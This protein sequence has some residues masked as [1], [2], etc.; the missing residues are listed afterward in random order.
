MNLHL[1]KIFKEDK[2]VA[3][4]LKRIVE[5]VLLGQRISEEEGILLYQSADLGMLSFLADAV[6]QSKNGN[7]ILHSQSLHIDLSNVC[8]Y[9]CPFCTYCQKKESPLAFT[10]SVKDLHDRLQANKGNKSYTEIV[11]SSA[12]HPDHTLNYYKE[13]V[14]LVRKTFPAAFIRAFSATDLSYI[15]K[16][17]KVSLNAGLAL[18][19]AAGVN[20]VNGG[21]AEI[22]SPEIRE[23]ISP[24]K[25]KAEEWIDFHESLHNAGIRSNASILYGH[26][27]SYKHRVEHMSRLRALQ[28]RTHGFQSFTAFKYK[29]ENN[30]LSALGEA[31]LVEDLRNF[32]VARIFLDNFQHLV[33]FTP[34]LNASSIGLT[35]SF[36][37]NCIEGPINQGTKVYSQP[38]PDSNLRTPMVV[39]IILNAK[40]KPKERDGLY[41]VL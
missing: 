26:I 21:G 3:A 19:K 9:A 14:D 25:I 6:G 4:P 22:F 10:L 17:E 13:V 38:S 7:T 31:P 24:E 5:K 32:A 34:M 40:K 41:N 37:V 20:A 30:R 18:L 11:I 29:K 1:F 2:M 39:E 12:C 35:L 8:A 23:K 33:A 16:K 27:E 36:G 28:D 15:F